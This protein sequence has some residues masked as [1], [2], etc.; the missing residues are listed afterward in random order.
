MFCFSVALNSICY[1]STAH[2]YYVAYPVVGERLLW[3]EN[4]PLLVLGVEMMELS[5]Y[6]FSTCRS[7][8]VHACTIMLF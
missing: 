3:R 4:T 6:S 7:T 5:K 1:D 2:Y 8:D